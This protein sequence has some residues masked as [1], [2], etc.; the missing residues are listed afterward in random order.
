MPTTFPTAI[1]LFNDPTQ[2]DTLGTPGVYHDVQHD[3]INDAVHQIELKLGVNNSADNNSVDYKVKNHKHL[4]TDG[5]TRL[6]ELDMTPLTDKQAFILRTAGSTAYLTGSSVAS[7]PAWKIQPNVNRIAELIKGAAAQAANLSEWQTN[8]GAVV[9]SVGP[10]GA[11]T[12]AALTTPGAVSGAAA[13]FSGL[14][15]AQNGLTLSA[16]ALALP[17]TAFAVGVD[18]GIANAQGVAATLARS[19]HVHKAP[20]M[21]VA[22]KAAI[23]SPV[24]GDTVYETVNKRIWSH[25]GIAWSLVFG[26]CGT[27]LR[28]VANQSINSAAPTAVSWD[29]ED[30]DTDGFITTPGT[31]VTIPSGLGGGFVIDAT[32]VF[33][34][35]PGTRGYIEIVAAGRTFR[36]PINQNEDTFSVEAIRALAPGDT[37][38]V[39][40]YQFTGAAVNWTGTLTILRF[41]N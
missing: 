7:E 37:I 34:T 10:A 12:C 26:R 17:S 23:T 19:S 2:Y 14:L 25:D 15:T 30:E 41:S 13:T 29:T 11:F 32:G 8:A 38:T 1:D 20:F 3:D 18:T 28:R 36:A 27:R 16:G 21:V 5:S 33:A 24:A 40:V 4:G 31:T 35:P 9:A 39:N 22:T 6:V